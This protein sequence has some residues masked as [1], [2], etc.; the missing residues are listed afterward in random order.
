MVDGCVLFTRD[1]D[2]ATYSLAPHQGLTRDYPCFPIQKV[3]SRHQLGR[4][5]PVEID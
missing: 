1:L 4:I 2:A 5:L 3:K